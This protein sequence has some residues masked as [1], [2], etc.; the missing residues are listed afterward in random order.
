MASI[1]CRH[2]GTLHTHTSVQEVKACQGVIAT[3][4]DQQQGRIGTRAHEIVEQFHEDR[5]HESLVNGIL[6]AINDN[7]RAFD[8]EI[9]RR[10]READ[11]AAAKYKMDR[12]QTEVTVGIYLVV[13][14]YYKVQ[15]NRDKTR[16]YAKKGVM[17]EQGKWHWEYDRGAI[18]GIKASDK[19]TAEE[20]KAFGDV[21]SNCI[22][23]FRD[24][25][26]PESVRRGYGPICADNYGWPYDHSARD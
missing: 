18:Y 7:E 21:H 11:E 10:E 24:L 4:I 20:A 9:Q 19:I 16:L 2:G 6:G 25:T 12:D 17:D 3:A 23:C 22:N 5:A 26:H 15:L 14:S 1:G 8:A 13:D